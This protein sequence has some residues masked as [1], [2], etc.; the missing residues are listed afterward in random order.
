MIIKKRKFLFFTSARIILD[1]QKLVRAFHEKKYYYLSGLSYR[2]FDFGPAVSVKQKQ[3]ILIDLVPQ[4]EEILASFHDTTRNEI[5]RTFRMP[6]VT[7]VSDDKNLRAARTLYRRFETFQKRIFPFPVSLVG[8]RLFS[9]YSHNELIAAV[10][11]YDAPPILRA[12]AIFS[13]R[14]ETHSPKERNETGY[15]TRRLV[16]E[17]SRWGHEHGYQF[18]D[19]GAINT[20]DPAKASITAFKRGFGGKEIDEYTYT[21]TSMIIAFLT[22]LKHKRSI[23]KSLLL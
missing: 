5:R 11:C 14:H 17:A 4:P 1:D 22:Y 15:A 12:R 3:T 9:A 2:R 6:D 8:H 18:F 10:L 7:F 23:E 21:S 20:R 16:Y 19:M 13:R